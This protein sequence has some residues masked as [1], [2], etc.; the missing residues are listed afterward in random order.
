VI[1]FLTLLH[2]FGYL[3]ATLRSVTVVAAVFV[4][5]VNLV[6]RK[7][8]VTL[9]TRVVINVCRSSCKVTVIL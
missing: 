4:M 6:T 5:K 2:N 3:C 1:H 7:S 9:V 8:V